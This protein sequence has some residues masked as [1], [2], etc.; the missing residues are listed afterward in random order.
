M[1]ISELT[2]KQRE[3]AEIVERVI[4]TLGCELV[5]Q[6]NGSDYKVEQD[7]KT[8]YLYFEFKGENTR[9]FPPNSILATA[10]QYRDL[11]DSRFKIGNRV[12]GPSY[13]VIAKPEDSKETAVLI[14]FIC[15]ALWC[16]KN[17]QDT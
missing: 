1:Q 7:G 10:K 8:C 13:D 15:R 9:T 3:V 11:E 17:E 5:L 12:Y 14:E 16:F 2:G 6:N 4:K